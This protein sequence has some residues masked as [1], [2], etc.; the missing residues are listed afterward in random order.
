MQGGNRRQKTFFCAD[1]YAYYLALLSGFSKKQWY[2]GLGLLS[3]AK[4]CSFG[5]GAQYHVEVSIN[6]G[7]PWLGRGVYILYTF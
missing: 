4:S 2:R 3:D 1:D 6:D 5:Y 7:G